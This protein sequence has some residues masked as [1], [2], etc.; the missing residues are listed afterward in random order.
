MTKTPKHMK[1]TAPSPVDMVVLQLGLPPSPDFEDLRLAV[2]SLYGRPLRLKEIR[3][4]ALRATT[5]IVFDAPTFTGIIVP[6]EDSSYYSLLSRVHELCH[7]I[8]RSAPDE[9]FSP[10]LPRFK[11]PVPHSHRFLRICPRNS[12]ESADAETVREEEVVEQM[13]RAFMRRL[14][15]FESRAEENYFG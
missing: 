6:A 5:G 15:T 11:Q 10:E 14:R 1:P 3:G 8:I 12:S 2:E 4:A 9:W 13:A 7:L